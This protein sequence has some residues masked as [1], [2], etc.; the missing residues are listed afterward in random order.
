[1]KKLTQAVAAASLISAGL[2]GAQVAHAELSFSAAVTSNYVWR[3]DTQTNDGTALQGSVGYSVGGLSLSVWQSSLEYVVNDSN[4]G[5]VGVGDTEVD[6][7]ASYSVEAGPVAL[8]GGVI[9]YDYNIDVLDF[10]EV[11][12]TASAMDLTLGIYKRVDDKDEN[13]DT[14]DQ[15]YVTLDYA[16]SVAEDLSLGFG[17]HKVIELE[18]GSKYDGIVSMT[19]STPNFDFTV[20]LTDKEDAE[21]EFVMTVSKGF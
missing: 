20:A 10:T 7:V 9:G 1:M 18:G 16:Y 4:G 15:G 5:E 21:N 3:G 11:Y 17:L 6:Y 19:K 12:V 14:D 2:M 8:T 13:K